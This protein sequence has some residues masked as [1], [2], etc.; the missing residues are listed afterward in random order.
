MFQV[1]L[2]GVYVAL[3]WWLLRFLEVDACLDAGGV[4]DDATENC[5]GT[6][7]GAYLSLLE[8]PLP[9]WF[10]SFLLPAIP[11]VIFG[12]LGSKVLR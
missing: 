8:R 12:F 9:F 2:V 5:I 4:I 7:P 1:L 10:I 11:V 6:R 3:F